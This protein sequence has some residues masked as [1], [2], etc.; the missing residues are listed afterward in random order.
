MSI[1]KDIRLKVETIAIT[2]ARGH[3]LAT[4]PTIDLEPDHLPLE[5]RETI[6]DPVA[7]T[8]EV[9]MMA[10]TPMAPVRMTKWISISRRMPT[11]TR[12]RR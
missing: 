1:L 2:P 11:R 4:A 5:A 7:G 8:Q 12:W 10:D 6:A 3:L 9:A